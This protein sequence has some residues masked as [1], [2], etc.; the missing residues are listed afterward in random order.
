MK[1]MITLVCLLSGVSAVQAADYTS[2]KA[3]LQD[4]VNTRKKADQPL[5]YWIDELIE[6]IKHE[7]K[8]SAFTTALKQ[9]HSDPEKLLSAFKAHSDQF[10]LGLK[11]F[12]FRIGQKRIK[13]AF[14]K[15]SQAKAP[16]IAAQAAPLKDLTP[17]QKVAV[18]T[19]PRIKAP[20]V[21]AQVEKATTLKDLTPGQK[22]AVCTTPRIK[23]PKVA[24]Q[25]EKATRL[26]D[27]TPGQKVAVCTTL[28]A[29]KP[30]SQ[31]RNEVQRWITHLLTHL[32]QGL[33]TP[34]AHKVPTLAQWQRLYAAAVRS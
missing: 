6:I 29:K 25:V 2:V 15:R 24:A 18:C 22:V 33:F 3:L 5:G 27:L 14:E 23:A 28:K 7:S 17:G 32:E 1:K 20:K 16:E 30:V 4:F 9:A 26:K 13:K 12:L 19:T 21:A 31:A 34:T 11:K 8:F 10:D